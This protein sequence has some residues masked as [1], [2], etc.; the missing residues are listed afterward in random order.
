[1]SAVR[2]EA[3]AVLTLRQRQERISWRQRPAEDV[4]ATV[5]AALADA[6]LPSR[7]LAGVRNDADIAIH[8]ASS[9]RGSAEYR[10]QSLSID[11]REM[12]AGDIGQFLV[13][14]T[15]LQSVWTAVRVTI[16]HPRSRGNEGSNRFDVNIIISALYVGGDAS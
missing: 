16:T 7:H 4:I 2:A 13:A 6:G 9:D 15:R 10:Q 11:L 3:Q 5:N 12:T 8:A 1:M 14:W